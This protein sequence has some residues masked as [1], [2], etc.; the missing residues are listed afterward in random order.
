MNIQ[1]DQCVNHCLLLALALNGNTARLWFFCMIRVGIGRISYHWSW[2]GGDNS[3]GFGVQG[4]F[5][6]GPCALLD[7]A[8][9]AMSGWGGGLFHG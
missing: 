3:L 1:D 6:S 9:G 4:D 7:R 2:G 5:V 8:F